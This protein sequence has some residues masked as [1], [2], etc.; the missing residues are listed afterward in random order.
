MLVYVQDAKTI[1]TYN[2]TSKTHTWVGT[3]PDAILAMH[4]CMNILRPCDYTPAENAKQDEDL[5]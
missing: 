4:C 3:M 2:L 5:D 1:K